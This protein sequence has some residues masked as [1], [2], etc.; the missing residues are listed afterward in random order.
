MG[1]PGAGRA[2]GRRASGR[3]SFVWAGLLRKGRRCADQAEA[4]RGG[5]SA[6]GGGETQRAS[7]W[8]RWLRSGSVVGDD[9]SGHKELGFTLEAREDQ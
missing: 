2:S 4:S 7:A 9:R 3:G 5:N 1:G 6:Q 8:E